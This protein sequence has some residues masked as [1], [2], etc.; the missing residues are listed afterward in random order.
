MRE[1][2]ARVRESATIPESSNS[3]GVVVAEVFVAVAADAATVAVGTTVVLDNGVA[4]AA[5]TT[6]IAFELVGD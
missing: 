1:A 4:V 6:G 5:T 3:E 2:S